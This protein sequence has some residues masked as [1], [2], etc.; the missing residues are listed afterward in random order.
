MQIEIERKVDK[1]HRF[2]CLFNPK[3]NDKMKVI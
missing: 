2:V 3:K 1:I